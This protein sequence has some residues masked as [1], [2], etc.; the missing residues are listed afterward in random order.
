MA[1]I[2]ESKKKSVHSTVRC[3]DTLLQIGGR[4]FLGVPTSRCEILEDA[5]VEV[6]DGPVT[7]K[8]GEGELTEVVKVRHLT[9]SGLF[10]EGWIPYSFV[11]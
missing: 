7:V 10:H 2:N 3:S 1:E 5:E 9:D 6:I 8:D 11:K 4:N